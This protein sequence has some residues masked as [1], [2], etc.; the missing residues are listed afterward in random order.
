MTMNNLPNI[1]FILAD[2]MGYGD[3]AAN[4]RESK[5]PTPAFLPV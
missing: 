5:I 3:M 4:N 2:D 1:I